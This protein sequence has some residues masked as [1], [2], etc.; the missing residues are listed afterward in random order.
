MDKEAILKK[1]QET[2]EYIVFKKNGKKAVLMS[3]PCTIFLLILSFLAIKERVFDAGYV[4]LYFSTFLMCLYLKAS[5][6]G[7]LQKNP[8]KYDISIIQK[9]EKEYHQGGKTIAFYKNKYLVTLEG[10]EVWAYDFAGVKNLS[11]YCF[12]NTNLKVG[13]SVIVFHH[14]LNHL[15]YIVS[16]E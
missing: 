6:K 10:D 7:F 13:S 4:V 5:I 1:L 14:T 2:E 12:G 15:I 3:I 8:M 16:N 11:G 9:I